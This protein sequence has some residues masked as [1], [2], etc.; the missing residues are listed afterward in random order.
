M[1]GWFKYQILSN[2]GGTF[3]GAIVQRPHD[4]WT[5]LCENE[6]QVPP[7]L[8]PYSI[9]FNFNLSEKKNKSS[10][11]SINSAFSLSILFP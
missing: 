7:R 6:N 10:F 9:W 11:Q 4:Y 2:N 5:L 8:F 3:R 1:Y